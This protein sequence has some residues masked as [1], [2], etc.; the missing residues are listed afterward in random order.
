MSVRAV[1]ASDAVRDGDSHADEEVSEMLKRHRQAVAVA[2]SLLPGK[3]AKRR[4]P[5]VRQLD[6]SLALNSS[7]PS[8]VD[9][10]SAVPAYLG[11]NQRR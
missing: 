4:L 3:H 5:N 10:V 6:T 8:E 9:T 2:E 1:L 7:N 11:L